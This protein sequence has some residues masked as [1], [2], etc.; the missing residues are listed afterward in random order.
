MRYPQ[1]IIADLGPCPPD[2]C[3]AR[4][5]PRPPQPTAFPAA[6]TTR[7]HGGNANDHRPQASYIKPP[8][9]AA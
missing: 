5:H 1:V 9:P 3:L 6:D 7:H 4:Q 8:W 2:S